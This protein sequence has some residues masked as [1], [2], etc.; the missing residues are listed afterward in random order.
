M[1][2]AWVE[3]DLGAFARNLQAVRDAAP[4]AAL[5]PMVKADAYGL[6][7]EAIWRAAIPLHPWG[8]GVAAVCEGE[9]LR[10]QGWS[11][12][13][14]VCPPIAPGEYARAAEARLTLA[15]SDQEALA[16]WRRAAETV[17][18][19]LAFHTEIDT[20]M[21]RAGF[22]A[23]GAA[24]WGREVAAAA[25]DL[26]RWEGCFTHFHSADEPDLSSAD[27]Q[28]E[29]FRRAAAE[30][31]RENEGGPQAVLHS[32]NSAAALRRA[33][34]GGALVRPGIFLYGGTA[35][36]GT[37]PAPVA[38]LRARVVRV[39]EAKAGDTLGYGATYAATGAERWATVAI[40]YGDGLPRCLAAS[41]G[42]AVLHG[43][44]VPIIGRISMD[45]TV[46]N[47]TG[48]DVSV[49]DVATFFGGEER[50]AI[51]VDEVAGRCGT[52]SYEILTGLGTRLPRVYLNEPR[53]GT[54]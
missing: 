52:I 54:P 42:E 3:V 33:G 32:A 10:A 9:A 30:L 29:R 49:G 26:L 51:S 11:G 25:G 39:R 35:G 45:V 38:A 47:V 43:R 28:F 41:G 48:T 17:G 5:L 22:P 27:A 20:G 36:P 15:L 40:G 18:E 6:G 8:L 16:A 4:G 37:H 53:S 24:R 44:R 14:L 23:D 13:I 1:S 7:A 19:R 31:P 21:G 50:G 34:F 12:R 46:V 2:R